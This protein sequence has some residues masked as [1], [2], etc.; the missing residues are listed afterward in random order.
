MLRFR[1]SSY[2]TRKYRRMSWQW[3]E[4]RET[5]LAV[6]ERMEFRHIGRKNGRKDG[7]NALT[8]GVRKNSIYKEGTQV[9]GWA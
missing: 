2:F 6:K 4:E 1:R 3:A 9:W 8:Y 5:R 7:G